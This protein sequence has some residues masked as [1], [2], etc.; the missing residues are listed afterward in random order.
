M[1]L[2]WE[3]QFQFA[4]YYAALWQGYYQ[5]VELDVE[6]KPI[7]R[8]DGSVVSAVDEIQ[9]GNAQFA[10]SSL[11]ILMAKD[12]GV[13]VVVLASIFQ[14]SQTAVFSLADTPIA[15]LSQLAKLRIAV[16][17]DNATKAEIGAVF[18]TQGFD[19]EQI[20]FVH[21]ENTIDALI[22]NEVDAIVTYEISATFEAQER[23]VKLNKLDPANFGVN[24]YGDTL[25]TS[26][27]LTLRDPKLVANFISAS[28]KGW[29]YAIENKEE[30]A[31]KIANE[32]PRH[33]FSYNDSH[34][35]NLAYA[36]L[37]DSLTGYPQQKIGEVNK[38]R[39]S[40]MND[41]LR[42]LGLVRS[43]LVKQ[44]LFFTPPESNTSFTAN[45]WFFL[46]LI[47]LMVLIFISW[48]KRSITLS[49][50]CILLFSYAIDR[51][52][53]QVLNTEHK[54]RSK[55]NLFRQL[56]S[57]SAKLEG[58]LQTNLSMLNGFAAYISAEPELSYEDFRQYAQEIFKKEPMLINFGT[59]K[60]LVINYVYPLE[61]NEKVIGLDYRN[62]V[63]QRDMVMQVVNSGQLLVVGPVKLV[64]GGL[65]FIGRVPIYT[66]NGIERTL[67]GIISA[68]LD[69]NALYLQSG[70]LASSKYFNLAIRSFDT[71][72][73]KGP[74][75]FG[76]KLTFEDPEAI[77]SVINVGAGTW[78]L[79]ATPSQISNDNE[80]NITIFRL[81]LTITTLIS[82]IFAVV[83]IRQQKE[84][85]NLQATILINQQLLENVGQVAKIG[86]WK[87]DQHLSFLQ[88]SK[89][90]SVLLGK[91]VDYLPSN[92]DE[93]SSSF[94]TQAFAVWKD[95]VEQAILSNEPFEFDIELIREND[96]RVW[97]R[98]IVSVSVQDDIS[99]VT[100]TMQDVTDKV[101]SAKIIEHQATYDALTE[102]PNRI[103]FNDRLRHAME[104]A[105]RK[106][107]K[108]AV[109]FIDLDKFKAVND[110]HGHQTGDKLLIAAASRINHCVRD[111]DTVS[112]LSG[113]EFGVILADIKQYSDALRVSE[114]I[115]NTLQQSYNIDDNV[116]HCSASI[117]IAFY[118]DDASDALSL[119]QKA[120]QAMYEVK[121][122][123]RNGYQ[124]Y[125]K[126]M[127]E[128][129]EYRHN[130]LN[131]L[132]VAVAENAITPYFQPIINLNTNKVSKC[133]SLARWQHPDGKYVPPDEF[134][135]LAEESGL[136]NKIDLSMLENSARELI[137]LKQQGKDIG[138]TINVSPRIFHT[139]DMA[140]KT[141]LACIHNFSQQLDITIEITER[142]LTDDSEK[143]LNVLNILRG[144]GVKIAIDDFGTGYS[145]LSYLIKFPVDIIKIDRSFVDAI[146]KES[147]AETLI[148]T[149]LLMAKNLG[150]QVVAEGIETQN[151]L[152]FL[153][154]YH[155]DYGQGYLLGRPM[156]TSK[157]ASFVDTN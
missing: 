37:I 71:Q 64:Q 18:K 150:I 95:S 83:R 66:G 86:G 131:D 53:V 42:E 105:N 112:R 145:S 22:N 85:L 118:P 144:Y 106:E 123:G 142:L 89:Q 27:Q 140:L 49:V 98:I 1:Q 5:D 9:N 155:C 113:D 55:L 33:L 65:A 43:H 138:L 87:L 108:V 94:E 111:Y 96:V 17:T 77:Q 132:I 133:E 115:Y 40:T 2:K 100:G 39:W 54:Q 36:N 143:A 99:I 122:S 20:N 114:I 141:W 47:T 91:P 90:S 129:S 63:P 82:C 56:T 57:I 34:K 127:Q 72:G 75:F 25:F 134:I 23:G 79:A 157:F 30:I 97:L 128:K 13:D 121:S 101:L 76:D 67:W 50:L 14:R 8:P 15:N 16:G 156:T 12:K 147:S 60:D 135:I 102:L 7:S 52:I 103:L 146:G 120:D 92:L 4:G 152:D 149:I 151:Q 32:L 21:T 70:V 69:A 61:G 26:Q 154:K 29:Q 35:Y 88:W 136:I 74:V 48:Y 11:D 84:K 31:N 125:T 139:K 107:N 59:A 109:L 10:I 119:I 41:K 62:N 19:V 3:H 130:L 78:H 137:L 116:L 80:A 28:I 117:G 73:K 58:D 68:P 6:I 45:I 81:I 38:E 93:I 44:E 51:Q 46:I 124:F 24:F 126:E 148:E 110:N 104:T 153:R